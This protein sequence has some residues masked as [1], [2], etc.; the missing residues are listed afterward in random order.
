[1]SNLAWFRLYSEIVDDDKILMLAFEDRWHYISILCLKN[2]NVIDNENDPDKLHR[3]IAIKL[4]VSPSN[5]DEIKRRLVDEDLIDSSWNPNGWN[6]RQYSSDS[7][8]DR[9]RKH[10]EK[11]R[12]K[13]A[14]SHCDVPVTPRTEQNR[15][16]QNKRSGNF[17]CF[18][19]AYP[20]KIGKQQALKSWNK[21]KPDNDL[22]KTILLAIE[23][24]EKSEQWKNE[25]GKFIPHAATWLN[26]MRWEDEAEVKPF[27]DDIGGEVI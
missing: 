20:K 13:D 4:G 6:D 16:E 1:L 8:R 9:T 7:S 15:A 25:N 14:E 10:R 27:H 12:L 5:L 18:W 24:N 2:R 22:L 23:S 21:L 26:G 17:D 3:K 19:S 11:Q